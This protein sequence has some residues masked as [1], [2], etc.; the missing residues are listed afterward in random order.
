MN[1]PDLMLVSGGAVTAAAGLMITASVLAA[2]P[3][4]FYAAFPL[5]A[6]GVV[7]ASVG[8]AK[9]DALARRM[10][11]LEFSGALGGTLQADPARNQEASARGP[12]QEGRAR[13]GP[14]RKGR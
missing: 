5:G 6:A 2:S 10:G 12:G 11:R 4:L 9:E 7:L 8:Y 14:R 3:A 1:R 13:E